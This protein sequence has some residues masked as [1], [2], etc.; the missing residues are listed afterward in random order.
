MPA[1][2]WARYGSEWRPRVRGPCAV[3]WLG[4]TRCALKPL[5]TSG[6]VTRCDAPADGVAGPFVH[7]EP[8]RSKRARGCS[9]VNRV[10]EAAVIKEGVFGVAWW[11]PRTLCRKPSAPSTSRTA[12]I[13]RCSRRCTGTCSCPGG[14]ME[15]SH[16][17]RR[18]G[19]VP[20]GLAAGLR[21]SRRD[22]TTCTHHNSGAFS[23]SRQQSIETVSFPAHELPVTVAPSTRSA[24]ATTRSAVVA[25]TVHVASW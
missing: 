2:E 16:G 12:P 8:A 9:I 10:M 18:P 13:G 7:V 4:V 11:R 15:S 3:L 14:S 21:G 19:S 6:V 23:P 20:C 24:A 5:R 1:R 25:G 17:G 22:T